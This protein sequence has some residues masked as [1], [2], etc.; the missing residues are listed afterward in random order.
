LDEFAMGF[1]L[2]YASQTE[3]YHCRILLEHA[4]LAE[5]AG[6]ETLWVSDHFHPWSHS[7]AQAGHTWV[8]IGAA[9]ARTS[10][11][12]FGTAV[13]CPLFRYNPAITAQAFATLRAMFPGRIFIGLG[14]GEAMNEIPVG[15]DW[16]SPKE[17]IERL[18]EAIQ[19]MKL[20]WSRSFVTFN[21]KYYRLRRAN[22]YTKPETPV[23]LYVAAFGPK[24]AKLA[25]KY[26]D[27]LLTSLVDPDR[28]NKVLLPAVAEGA[29]ETG[30]D[31]SG[32]EKVVELGVAYDEDYDKAVK[33][34]RFWAGTLFPFMFK[35]PIYDPREIENMGKLVSDEALA[36]AFFI[37]TKAEDIIK[38]I[39]RA[40]KMGFDHAYLQSTSPDENRFFEIAEKHVVPYIKSTYG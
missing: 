34:V 30:R 15:Y 10:K 21:G 16:P 40:V 32:I 27:G 6:F 33:K 13:T 39:E 20:L 8:I 4:V 12:K 7:E 17:R 38:P 11:I 23:P 25:G 19:I 28:L 22:L 26:A 5:K 29:K 18:D 1:T 31:P 2:G 37:C 9:A 24:V 36:K 14:A 3:L 35:L